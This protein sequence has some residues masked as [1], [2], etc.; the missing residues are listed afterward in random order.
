MLH[1]TTECFK[2]YRHLRCF[3]FYR[4]ALLLAAAAC[5][6]VIVNDD[7]TLTV[8]IDNTQPRVAVNEKAPMNAHDG[9]LFDFSVDAR[10]GHKRYWIVGTR[11]QTKCGNGP[12]GPVFSELWP[13][14]PTMFS[15]SLSFLFVFR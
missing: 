3:S 5:S 8:E 9:A 7:K 15:K 1:G 10:L 12:C 6:K 4:V 2:I 14:F 13:T 11:Y